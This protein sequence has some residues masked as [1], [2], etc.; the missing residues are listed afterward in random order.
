MERVREAV[1][2]LLLGVSFLC[3]LMAA[4][5]SCGERLVLEPVDVDVV[6]VDVIMSSEGDGEAWSDP[7]KPADGYP[8]PPPDCT[9]LME[10]VVDLEWFHHP[11]RHPTCREVQIGDTGHLRYL[12]TAEG[13][14][15]FALTFDLTP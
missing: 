11:G 9:F 4:A 7:R 10:S 1:S 3:A 15:I 13:R 14:R 6:V 12:D 5:T 2:G 8:L